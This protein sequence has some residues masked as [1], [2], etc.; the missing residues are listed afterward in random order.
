MLVSIPLSD[1]GGPLFA[2]EA[3][4]GEALSS[5]GS[6]LRKM[7]LS[8]RIAMI[9][10]NGTEDPAAIAIPLGDMDVSCT[11][12]FFHLDLKEKPPET[13]WNTIFTNRDA[14]RN[15]IRRLEKEGFSSAMASTQTEF[16]AFCKLHN[17]TVKKAGGSGHSLDLPGGHLDVDASRELQCCASEERRK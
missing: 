12:G 7:T 6:V 13:I 14:Q 11:G 16:S 15:R 10:T 4:K 8:R 17:E 3:N 2:E 5:F 9:L 1:I